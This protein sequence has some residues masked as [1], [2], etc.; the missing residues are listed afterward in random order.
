M[1][2]A[3]A[4]QAPSIGR[5]IDGVEI[6]I[7]DEWRQPVTEGSGEIYISGAGLAR[8][9]RNSQDLTAERFIPNKIKTARDVR[10][11]RT[12]DLG[13]WL[14]NGDCTSA[15][16]TSASKFVVT[17]LSP[18]KCRRAVS[19]LAKT[20]PVVATD[21]APGEIQ[22]VAYLVLSDGATVSATALREHLRQRVPD[23]MIPA[24]FVVIPSLPVTEQGKVN[25]AALPSV[26]GNRL[27]DEVYVEPRTLVEEEL[28]KIL[29]PLLKLDRVGVNDN[30]FFFG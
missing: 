5:A 4:N 12:G 27:A 9:Y 28:V 25:R 22:L 7:L 24:S 17:G 11:Y 26:N 15:G 18:A 1:N 29:A 19:I 14:P 20:S 2:Q 23:Y 8:G 10:L 13:R 3:P 16:W 21:D 6:Y 30:F